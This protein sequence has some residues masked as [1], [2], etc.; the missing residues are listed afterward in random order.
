MARTHTVTS[1][2]HGGDVHRAIRRREL[3]RLRSFRPDACRE[4][5]GAA[6]FTLGADASAWFVLEVVMR[7]RRRP[8][9]GP[10]KERGLQADRSNFWPRLG[11]AQHYRG[12]CARW[13]EPLGADAEAA[14]LAA[15]GWNRRGAD[16]RP[17]EDDRG[18]RNWDYRY[19]W[20]RD[21]SFTL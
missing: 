1:Q 9:R 8:R 14:H 12:R 4:W 15:D 10:T 19:T 2:R 16:L 7:K 6:E 13:R 5:R 20:I 18:G 11:R 17:S 3:V 21:S